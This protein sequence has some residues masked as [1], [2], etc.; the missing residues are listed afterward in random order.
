[1]RGKRHGGFTLQEHIDLG[2]QLQDLHFKAWDLLFF[3]QEFYPKSSRQ[4][5]AVYR[6]TAGPYGPLL[7]S[8]TFLDNQFHLEGHHRTGNESPWFPWDREP[9]P[10]LVIDLAPFMVPGRRRYPGRISV[11]QHKQ[12]AME[13][14]G[15][16]NALGAAAERIRQAYGAGSAAARE[17]EQITRIGGLTD[18]LRVAL[19]GAARQEHGSGLPMN[20]Y[21]VE[22]FDRLHQG[23]LEAA[24]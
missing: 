13:L 24:G 5:R 22:A 15:I 16:Q 11:E 14:A 18:R 10:N 3:L 20:W 7:K 2:R 17:L 21:W 6:I 12:L 8:R 4:M 1:M 23:D 9:E 19:E